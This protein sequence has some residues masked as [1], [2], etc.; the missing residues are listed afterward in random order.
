MLCK[1]FRNMVNF[2][3]EQFSAPRPTSN[4]GP[5]LINRLR[6][7]IQYIRNYALYVEAVLPS[8]T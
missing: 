7:L 1:V 6:L 2:Y 3:R 5:P 4:V 8:A